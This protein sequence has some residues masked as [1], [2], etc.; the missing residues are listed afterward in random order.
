MTK[1]E[2]TKFYKDRIEFCDMLIK[3]GC[4]NPIKMM[5]LKQKWEYKLKHLLNETDEY[6]PHRVF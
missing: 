6:N 2:K 4:H 5:N 1:T 3:R